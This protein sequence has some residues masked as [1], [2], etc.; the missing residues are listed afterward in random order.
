MFHSKLRHAPSNSI[1]DISSHYS[2]E[3]TS[4]YNF[5]QN[6][7][8]SHSRTSS[9]ISHRHL[10]HSPSTDSLEKVFIPNTKQTVEKLF[11]QTNFN[12]ILDQIQDTLQPITKQLRQR[13]ERKKYLSKQDR[14][15]CMKSCVKFLT[16][17]LLNEQWTF[18]DQFTELY[19]LQHLLNRLLLNQRI[20]TS[21]Q[22]SEQLETHMMQL[23]IDKTLPIENLKKSSKISFVSSDKQYN[24]PIQSKDHLSRQQIY[25]KS[26]SSA[27]KKLN[28]DL[29]KLN[30]ETPFK[31][32]LSKYHK[33]N[34]E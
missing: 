25:H 12:Q 8:R 29:Q 30:H 27:F 2:H 33:H 13:I 19:E 22:A 11:L 14:L 6:R 24:P 4:K 15:F 32:H 18:D 26:V 34:H 16:E 7:A 20:N 3:P 31:A 5:N 1:I 10:C 17:T 21:V 28:S 9:F 23:H